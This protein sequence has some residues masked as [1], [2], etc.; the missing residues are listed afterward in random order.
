MRATLP[1]ITVKNMVS[2]VFIFYNYKIESVTVI[3]YIMGIVSDA[4]IIQLAENNGCSNVLIERPKDKTRGKSTIYVNYTCECGN[5]NGGTLWYRFK[6]NPRCV[7]CAIAIK[8]GSDEETIRQT[9]IG[10]NLEYVGHKRVFLLGNV[11]TFVKFICECDKDT[12]RIIKESP[13]EQLKYDKSKCNIC[14]Q[15][16]RNAGTKQAFIERG[17]EINAKRINTVRERYGVDYVT[18]DNEIR[19]RSA[20]NGYLSKKYIFPSGREI[21]CQGYEPL[22]YDILLKSNIDEDDIWTDD[23]IGSCRA[24]PKF[25]YEFCEIQHRYFP[26]IYVASEDK[27]IEVKSDYTMNVEYDKNILKAQTVKKYGYNIEIWIFNGSKKLIEILR[28]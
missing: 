25:I 9:L 13:I 17:D 5:P 23:V 10:S 26:D 28:F 2:N 19:I 12:T 21:S 16:R 6:K 4:E 7:G 8:R 18:Q 20:K 15:T 3:S 24:F 14:A 1:A 27:F 22:A 11:K